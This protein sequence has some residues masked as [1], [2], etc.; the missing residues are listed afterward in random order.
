MYLAGFSGTSRIAWGLAA[1]LRG[2]VAGI[3][4]TGGAVSFSARGPEMVFGADSTFAFFGSAGTTDFN[5]DE[6]RSFASR[7]RLARVPSRFAWFSGGHAWPPRELCEQA[8]DW[9]ELRA[10]LGGR[11][12]LDTAFV[13][14]SLRRDLAQADSLERAGQ[15]D[16]AEFRY[17]EIALDVP[18]RDEGRVA[19]AHADDLAG[20]EPLKALRSRIRE[21][22][23]EDV[24]D[25]RREF[26]ALADARTSRDPL[27]PDALL[28][29]LGVEP[30]KRR[31][32]SPDSLERSSA[33][34]RLSNVLAF[35]SFYEPRAFLAGDQ[36]QRAAASLR[37]AA[38]IAPLRGESCE[39][40][41]R[42]AEHLPRDDAARL[43]P[44][45]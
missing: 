7:L 43:P 35:I 45:S 20:R 11:R 17:R 39:L 13:T 16:P 8:V 6:M 31:L 4:G 30:L 23:E 10:I 21:L 22:A 27:S 32:A 19:L 5:Y 25:S 24:A 29:K 14:R 28:E 3:F 34:R 37:A 2:K 41:R 38:S 26:K 15:W 44:C 40:A 36:P 18:A 42:A 12:A 1:E 9:F 33:A